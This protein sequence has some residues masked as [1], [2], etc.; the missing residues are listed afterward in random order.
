M[1][2][3]IMQAYFLPYIGYFQ[4]VDSVDTIVFYKHLTF[5]KKSYISRN[6]IIEKGTGHFIPINVPI[7]KQSSNTMIAETKILADYSWRK[8]LLHLIAHNYKKASH[9]EEVYPFIEELINNDTELIHTY[10]SEIITSLCQK[11]N[12][13]TKIIYNC[14]DS[15]SIEDRLDMLEQDTGIEKKSL[16]IFEICEQYDSNHYVNPIGGKALYDKTI[17]S[18]AGFQLDFVNTLPHSYPQFGTDF[19]SNMSIVDVLMHCG[20]SGTEKLIKNNYTLV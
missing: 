1:R 14:C 12:I 8:R 18:Q 11:L 10:N 4:L 9:Y 2:L 6:Q 13:N 20:F 16:R 17:F 15:L 19:H 7:A 3:S 5:R